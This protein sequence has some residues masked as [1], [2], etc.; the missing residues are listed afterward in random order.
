M[1]GPTSKRKKGEGR[2]GEGRGTEGKGRGMVKA[3]EAK[4]SAPPK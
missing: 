3:S 4:K 2:E 1:R